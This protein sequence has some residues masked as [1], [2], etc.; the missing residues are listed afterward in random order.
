M[1][2]HFRL[3][4]G[5]TNHPT[6]IPDRESIIPSP[7][8]GEGP[9]ILVNSIDEAMDP[10]QMMKSPFSTAAMMS[11]AIFSDEGKRDSSSETVLL[12]ANPCMRFVNCVLVSCSKTKPGEMKS[13]GKAQ[14][15]V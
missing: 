7:R 9:I 1:A 2:S 6:N 3:R 11:E 15:I 14:W 13:A 5:Q 4:I 10:G 12:V 8:F